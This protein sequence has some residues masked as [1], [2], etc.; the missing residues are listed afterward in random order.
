MLFKRKDNKIKADEFQGEINSEDLTP[1]F[2]G[3]LPSQPVSFSPAYIKQ[4]KG[5]LND[6]LYNYHEEKTKRKEAE[7]M[8][9]GLAINIRTL[10]KA[11]K[12]SHNNFIKA[13]SENEDVKKKLNSALEELK[14]FKE[15]EESIRL[16]LTEEKDKF[17]VEFKHDEN[18]KNI[19]ESLLN[20]VIN[21]ILEQLY[22]YL[23]ITAIIFIL[24]LLVSIIILILI[25]KK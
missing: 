16:R 5:W 21:Y 24:T 23:I 6:L 7:N 22:P 17:I 4:L 25:I 15:N 18:I 10:E 3:V 13:K 14:T 8:S 2:F 1:E 19:K 9:C 12:E 11:N 20:P